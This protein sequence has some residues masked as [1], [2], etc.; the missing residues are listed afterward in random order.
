M[1]IE[2]TPEGPRGFFEDVSQWTFVYMNYVFAAQTLLG[3]AV[4][5]GSRCVLGTPRPLTLSSSIAVMWYGN[6][7]SSWFFLCYF[8][9]ASLVRVSHYFGWTE[10]I[11]NLSQVTG[12]EVPYTSAHVH[13][14]EVFGG[15]L[16]MWITAFWLTALSTNVV[17][18]CTSLRL[19][20]CRHVLK[21]SRVH[22]RY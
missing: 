18:T 2:T 6:P 7:N 21:S 15:Q 14:Q 8:G 13:Q 4:V 11:D 9:V 3:D 1:N 22:Q 16:A 12:I 19:H 10:I 5:V 20:A 17:T